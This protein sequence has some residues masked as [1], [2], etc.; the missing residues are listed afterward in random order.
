MAQSKYEELLGEI[1]KEHF[2]FLHSPLQRG[3]YF[4]HYRLSAARRF[5]FSR[6]YGKTQHKGRKEDA[7]GR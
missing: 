6:I 1:K 4:I 5:D 7:D 3:Q 2:S